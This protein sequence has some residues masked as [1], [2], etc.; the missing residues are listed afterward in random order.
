MKKSCEDG[1]SQRDEL[2]KRA[3]HSTR[4][5]SNQIINSPQFGKAEG[6]CE[7]CNSGVLYLNDG[8]IDG[9]RELICSAC[10]ARYCYDCLMNLESENAHESA[11]TCDE[12]RVAELNELR[13]HTTVCP[14]CG[15]RIE[16]VDN[17]CDDMFCVFCH[18]GFNYHTRDELK[19]EFENEERRKWLNENGRDYDESLHAQVRKMPIE[20][21]KDVVFVIS[22]SSNSCGKPTNKLISGGINLIELYIELENL[23][24]MKKHGV[25]KQQLAVE[26]EIVREEFSDFIYSYCESFIR[27]DEELQFTVIEISRTIDELLTRLDL[28]Q[29]ITPSRSSNEIERQLNEIVQQAIERFNKNLKLWIDNFAMKFNSAKNNLEFMKKHHSS[30]FTETIEQLI[31]ANKTSKYQQ[32]LDSLPRRY[33]EMIEFT[34]YRLQIRI[35]RCG[36]YI[37]VDTPRVRSFDMLLLT[38]DVINH[39][40][41]RLTDG[42]K[43]T[44]PF[45]VHL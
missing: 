39:S 7:K 4:E 5:F 25:S 1:Y 19:C 35:N 30:L 41:F 38:N 2:I 21:L 3:Y 27:Y 43:T 17:T 20:L 18:R 34:G 23:E 12:A 29:R 10:S 42:S 11:H 44:S 26:S 9:A 37:D 45:T 8:F 13:A 14:F 22:I 32:L 28:L 6:I 36:R 16:K 15:R 40:S 24:V 33:K 31:S